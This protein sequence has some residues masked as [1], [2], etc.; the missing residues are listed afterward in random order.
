MKLTKVIIAA[1]SLFIT[2]NSYSQVTEDMVRKI[3]ETADEPEMVMQN[4][5]LM[6][7]GYLYYA[8]ILADRLREMKPQNPNYHYRKGFLMLEIRKDY[9]ANILKK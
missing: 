3:A 8:E 7:E 2:W 6:Q 1:L 5:T 9:V 4:S